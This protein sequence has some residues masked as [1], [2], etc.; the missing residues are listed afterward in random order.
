MDIKQEGEKKLVEE[1]KKK[2][3]EDDKRK[4]EEKKIPSQWFI[5]IRKN[6]EK[7]IQE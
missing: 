1:K 4:K 6:T 7:H 3:E 5:H 2:E